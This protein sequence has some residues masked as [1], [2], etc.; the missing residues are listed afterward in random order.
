MNKTNLRTSFFLGA[1]R[2][3]FECLTKHSTPLSLRPEDAQKALE[4]S[5]D[6]LFFGTRISVVP[7]EGFGKFP[8]S[9][10]IVHA[11][12]FFL[13]F[14]LD[15]FF[16]PERNAHFFLIVCL[17][18]SCA[19]CLFLVKNINTAVITNHTQSLRFSAGLI[20]DF[21]RFVQSAT[22][23][24][25]QEKK[26]VANFIAFAARGELTVTFIWCVRCANHSLSS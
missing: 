6:K 1:N 8:P 19:A 10:M 26:V 21:S 11:W 15:I 23:T 9:Q 2:S 20:I 25:V 22:R 16:P 13:L 17:H 14:Q 12:F 5:H 3:D 24:L 4:A 18:P 7:H